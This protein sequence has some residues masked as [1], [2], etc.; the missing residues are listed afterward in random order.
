MYLGERLKCGN[1]Q[2]QLEPG[3]WMLQGAQSS[4]FLTSAAFFFRP[5]FFTVRGTWLPDQMPDLKE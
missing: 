3:I 1:H 4:V 5:A 2:G